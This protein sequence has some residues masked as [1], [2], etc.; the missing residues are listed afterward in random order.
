MIEE[1][2]NCRG[3]ERVFATNGPLK[4]VN[5]VQL[6]R[7]NLGATWCDVVGVLPNG[8]FTSAQTRLVDDSADGTAWLITGGEWGLRLRLKSSTEPWD[9]NNTLQ[10]GEP[11]LVMDSGGKEIQ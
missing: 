3:E 11:F 5:A 6:D 8:T 10:W 7:P 9:L 4:P 1:N 2:P